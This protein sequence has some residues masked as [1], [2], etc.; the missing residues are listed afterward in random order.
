[1]G[2]AAN[3]NKDTLVGLR[4]KQGGSTPGLPDKLYGNEFWVRRGAMNGNG[5]NNPSAGDRFCTV[6]A[7]AR[8][9]TGHPGHDKTCTGRNR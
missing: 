9:G 1:M 3:R 6:R 4:A 8:R 7:A 5:H 2:L